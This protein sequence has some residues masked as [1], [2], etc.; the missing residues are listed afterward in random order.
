MDR[1]EQQYARRIADILAERAARGIPASADV[2]PAVWARLAA[3]EREAPRTRQRAPRLRVWQAV[4]AGLLAAMFLAL[5]LLAAVP[6]IQAALNAQLRSRFGLVLIDPQNPPPIITPPAS[7]PSPGARVSPIVGMPFCTPGATVVPCRLERISVA[8][9]QRRVAFPLRL[10]T[11]LP[12]DLRVDRALVL[13]TSGRSAS[14][15]AG[16]VQLEQVQGSGGGGYAVEAS[17]VQEVQVNGRPA[18]Y[19]RGGWRSPTVWDETLNL[20]YLSWEADGVT[21]T[22][23]DGGL[24]L[25]RETLIR[26]AESLR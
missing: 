7:V 15:F 19:A 25:D 8:E 16:P 11:W 5:G 22:L 21:Y 6:Q 3:R 2:R 1:Q 18:A 10:P 4:G 20:N 9:A 24:G 13:G 17:R 12:Y 23:H 26:I 14:V